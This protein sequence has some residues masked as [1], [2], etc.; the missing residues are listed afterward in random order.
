M[1]SGIDS[2]G[3]GEEEVQVEVGVDVLASSES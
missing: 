3:Y 1:R 2:S